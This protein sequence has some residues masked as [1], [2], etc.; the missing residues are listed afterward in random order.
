MTCLKENIYPWQ[1]LCKILH[2]IYILNAVK[3]PTGIGRTYSEKK[4]KKKKENKSLREQLQKKEK[5]ESLTT[6]TE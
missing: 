1:P 4:K 6:V 2:I 3:I 5:W